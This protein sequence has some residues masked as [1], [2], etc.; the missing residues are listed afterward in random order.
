MRAMILMRGRGAF[1]E[2]LNALRNENERIYSSN[3]IDAA[4]SK[5]KLDKTEAE[6]LKSL[7]LEVERLRIDM[8]TLTKEQEM[9]T[10]RMSEIDTDIRTG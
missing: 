3:N 9:N 6:K 10:E 2:E 1:L 5:G 8:A 4:K 7:R